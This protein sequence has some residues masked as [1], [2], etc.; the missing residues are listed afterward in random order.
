MR[1]TAAQWHKYI[2][3]LSRVDKAAGEKMKAFLDSQ[4][5]DYGDPEDIEYIIR[6][7]YGLSTKYGDAVSELACEMYDMMSEAQG[8]NV[9]PAEPADTATYEETAKAVRG[10]LKQSET[11]QK[12][13]SVVERLTKQAG[14]DTML[15]NARRDNAS[16]A[17]VPSGDT[18][19]YCLSLAAIGWQKAGKTTFNGKHAEHIHAHCDCT[20]AVDFK[21]NLKIEGYD[22]DDCLQQIRDTTGD[23]NLDND[24]MIRMVGHNAKGTNDYEYLNVMRRQ[25]YAANKDTINAQKREAYAARAEKS[26]I[27]NMK[28]GGASGKK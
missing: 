9:P 12:I 26:S 24:S 5:L 25:N 22:P 7:A 2:N 14:A 16:F 10:S 27:E 15:K 4:V 20:Y 21:G 8:A 19:P 13:S 11:G 18:C 28:A 6:Y 23:Q 17:W 3:A 1:I